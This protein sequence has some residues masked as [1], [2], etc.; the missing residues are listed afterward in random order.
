MKI[1]NACLCAGCILQLTLVKASNQTTRVLMQNQTKNILCCKSKIKIKLTN[2]QVLNNAD[3][4]R[5][6]NRDLGVNE[7]VLGRTEKVKN[8]F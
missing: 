3:D 7:A 6:K 8:R 1:G 4:K 5:Q 2:W